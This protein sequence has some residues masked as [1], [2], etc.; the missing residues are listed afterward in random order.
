MFSVFFFGLFEE[1]ITFF[2]FRFEAE[3]RFLSKRS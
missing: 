2:A 3:S 1:L